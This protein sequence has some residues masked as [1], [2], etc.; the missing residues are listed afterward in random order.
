MHDALPLVMIC[1]QVSRSELGRH[2]FQE[3]DYRQTFGDLA[4]WVTQVDHPS[5]LLETVARAI[6]IATSG[7][8]GPVVIAVP[9]D[10]F[11][12][13]AAPFDAALAGQAG[14]AVDAATVRAVAAQLAGAARPL[15]SAG[16]LLNT[17]RGRAA[18]SAVAALLALIL[19]PAELRLEGKGTLEPVHRR[20]VFAGIDGVVE[21]LDAAAGVATEDERLRFHRDRTP[22]EWTGD[23]DEIGRGCRHELPTIAQLSERLGES[24]RMVRLRGP[25]ACVFN[26]IE[27]GPGVAIHKG[28]ETPT[29]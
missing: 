7:R 20:D 5:K 13:E 22:I 4:K 17:P 1:G 27:F 25:S 28:K 19:I 3:V 6:D 2:A 10:V 16:N 11:E 18:L 24:I 29:P 12:G 14:L 23:A 21:K 15:L 9:E 8:P 26:D